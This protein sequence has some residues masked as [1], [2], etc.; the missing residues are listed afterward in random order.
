[1]MP[2]SYNSFG[3]TAILIMICVLA[4]GQ[5]I[6]YLKEKYENRHHKQQH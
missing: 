1:M 2:L 3:F 5:A 4:A 6:S